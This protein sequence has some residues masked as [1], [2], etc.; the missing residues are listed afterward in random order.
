M[1]VL[2]LLIWFVVGLAVGLI[3]LW[4]VLAEVWFWGWLFRFIVCL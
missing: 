3:G 2:M 4:W 1:Y